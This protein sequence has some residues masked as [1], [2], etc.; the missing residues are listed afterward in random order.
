MRWLALNLHCDKS[1][2]LGS[3]GNLDLQQVLDGVD[4][5]V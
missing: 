4:V 2:V 3:L 5:G 1:D